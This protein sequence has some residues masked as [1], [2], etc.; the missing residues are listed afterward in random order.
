MKITCIDKRINGN[1]INYY[2]N[3][4][5]KQLRI[6]FSGN[7]DLYFCLHNP[8]KHYIK[9]DEEDFFEIDKEYPEL[10]KSFDDL[11]NKV[12]GNADSDEAISSFRNV[13]T[14]CLLNGNDILWHSD[15]YPI[16]CGD[17]MTIKKEENT[18][19]LIFKRYKDDLEK[20]P[21]RSEDLMIRISNSGSRYYPYNNYFMELYNK[22]ELIYSSNLETT[23][24][25]LGYQKTIKAKK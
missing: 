5:Q 7:G 16:K 19:K 23:E 21:D 13:H 17:S 9:K 25:Y 11:Y 6:L 15:D 1:N 20:G 8:S 2:I 18:Y 14:T 12:F 3:V 4:E 24:D 10:Y 22:L